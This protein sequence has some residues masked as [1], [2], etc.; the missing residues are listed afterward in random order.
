MVVVSIKF[1]L[2]STGICCRRQD[3]H[4]RFC[5]KSE[6]LRFSTWKLVSSSKACLGVESLANLSHSA[7]ERRAIS[8]GQESLAELKQQHLRGNIDDHYDSHF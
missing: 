2:A 8:Q 3:S 4:F 1:A 5:T 7:V 6:F